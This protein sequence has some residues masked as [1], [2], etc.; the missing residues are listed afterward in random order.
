MGRRCDCTGATASHTLYGAG[1]GIIFTSSTGLCRFRN[2][3]STR[4][5][6]SPLVGT[7]AA[8]RSPQELP[9]VNRC[10]FVAENSINTGPGPDRN[11]S[12][13]SHI[14]TA[15]VCIGHCRPRPSRRSGG[16]GD[17]EGG[18]SQTG[19][20][21]RKSSARGRTAVLRWRI[22]AAISHSRDHRP[23]LPNRGVLARG[24]LGQ[25]LHRRVRS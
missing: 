18:E 11:A 12:P 13:Q 15:T 3:C 4:G 10:G 23:R 25:R 2:R 9:L 21:R 22:G 19:P 7:L 6:R 24:A 16:G 17:R 1:D 5:D 14:Q 8:Q 20:S